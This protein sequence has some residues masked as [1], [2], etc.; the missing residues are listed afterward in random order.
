MTVSTS[1]GRDA[2]P[3]SLKRFL[4]TV[5]FL[6]AFA[7]DADF[8]VFPGELCTAEAGL[9]FAVFS[10]GDLGASTGEV[11]AAATSLSFVLFF[12]EKEAEL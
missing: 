11:F 8:G 7:L 9:R 3:P 4:L 12:G 1:G 2:F 10:D 6:V 5:F